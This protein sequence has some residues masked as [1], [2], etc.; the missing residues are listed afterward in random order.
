MDTEKKLTIQLHIFSDYYQFIPVSRRI[1]KAKSY[2]QAH[3][4][5]ELYLFRLITDCRK[6]SRCKDIIGSLLIVINKSLVMAIEMSG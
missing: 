6:Y 3:L 2:Q 5:M 1:L 4:P